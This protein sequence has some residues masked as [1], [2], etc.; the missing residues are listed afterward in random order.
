MVDQQTET[1]ADPTGQ[2]AETE[3]VY[4]SRSVALAARSGNEMWI[5]RSAANAMV[6]G[7]DMQISNSGGSALVAGGNIEVSGG[8]GGVLVA[9]KSAIINHG[10][11]GMIF[12]QETVLGEGSRVLLD[13]PQAIAFGAAL[14]AAFGTVCWLLSRS[15]AKKK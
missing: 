7:K 8:G 10:V 14:G 9:G 4:L 13:R 6:A 11:V 3:V 15:G 1:N 12:S 5:S 2:T